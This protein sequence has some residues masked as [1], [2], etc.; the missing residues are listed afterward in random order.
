ME[1]Y[2]D[3]FFN[4]IDNAESAVDFAKRVQDTVQTSFEK[5]GYR[6]L[7]ELISKGVDSAFRYV[8]PGVETSGFAKP[9]KVVDGLSYVQ[10]QLAEIHYDMRRRGAFRDG[11]LA[12]LKSYY[13]QME[14]SKGGLLFFE[15]MI[16]D[17]L[18]SRKKRVSR[19]DRYEEGYCAGLEDLINILRDTRQYLMNR[20]RHDLLK[21]NG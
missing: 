12:A 15:K 5:S 9:E 14:E 7:G 3:D 10:N 19:H 13:Q 4:E 6:D 17:D 2:L 20:V 8:G 1:E 16:R 21:Q 18:A 11:H